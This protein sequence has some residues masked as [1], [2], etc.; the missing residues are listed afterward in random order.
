M[1]IY[2]GYRGLSGMPVSD[3]P[4]VNAVYMFCLLLSPLLKPEFVLLCMIH[5]L[6]WELWQV[7]VLVGTMTPSHQCR[8]SCQR[9]GTKG[10][11]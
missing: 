3:K 1:K 9:P 11:D 7:H 5:M 4:D 6:L 10:R 8:K 2:V